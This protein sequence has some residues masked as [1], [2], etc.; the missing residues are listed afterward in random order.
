MLAVCW[1]R[2]GRVA[3]GDLERRPGD[4]HPAEV[5]IATSSTGIVGLVGD[6]IAGVAGNRGRRAFTDLVFLAPKEGLHAA[7][8]RRVRTMN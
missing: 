4:A 6:C 2:A 8:V 1:P 5:C 7:W 3:G